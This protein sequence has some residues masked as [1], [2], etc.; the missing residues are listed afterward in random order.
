LNVLRPALPA[1]APLPQRIG[2]F[3]RRIA[4]GTSPGILRTSV[5]ASHIFGVWWRVIDPP[6]SAQLANWRGLTLCAAL[7]AAPHNGFNRR[8]FAA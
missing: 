1:P 5:I 7:L 4:I 8:G 3:D 2:A 6:H